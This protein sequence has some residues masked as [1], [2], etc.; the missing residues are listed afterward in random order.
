MMRKAKN[1][2]RREVLSLAGSGMTGLALS[3]WAGLGHTQIPERIDI[4]HHW[5]PPPIEDAFG[6]LSIGASWPGRSGMD[7][8]PIRDGLKTDPGWT[9][10]RSGVEPRPIQNGAQTNPRSTSD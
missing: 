3:G 8:R 5:H 9:Q 7:H 4:H 10:N 6:G 1:L 2:T